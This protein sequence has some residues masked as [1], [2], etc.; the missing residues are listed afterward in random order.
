MEHENSLTRA[1]K[2][3]PFV[4]LG[5]LGIGGF[6]QTH[7]ARVMDKELVKEFGGQEVVA[8]K[9]PLPEKVRTLKRDLEMNTLLHLRLKELQAVNLVR[10]LGFDFFKGT[11]VLAFEY[12]EGGSLRDKI[13]LIG[14]QR[15][16]DPEEAVKIAEGVLQG[17]SVI[18]KEGIFHRDIKPENILIHGEIPKIADLGL[19]RILEPNGYASTSQ[20]TVQY[21][22]PDCLSTRGASF[23]SDIWSL[24]V[25]L[26]EMVTGRLPFGEP[27]TAIGNLVDLIRHDRHVPACEVCADVP[28][29]LSKIIDQALCKNPKDRFSGADEMLEALRSLSEG[30]N[31]PLEKEI[32]AIRELI[33]TFENP[34]LIESKLKEFVGQ[35][36]QNPSGYQYLGEFYNRCQRHD[37]ALSAF[38]KGLKIEPDSAM[39]RWNLA[40]TYQKMGKKNNAVQNL[41]KAISSGLDPGLQRHARILLKILR[42]RGK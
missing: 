33:T 7:K 23:T 29:A 12:I 27:D 6:A 5:L 26:Y 16:L 4:L 3:E 38:K 9:I 17:L 39:L 28:T 8:L 32:S 30:T 13:G 10:Y 19:S 42:G 14:A 20:G 40:L 1:D 36:N 31:D 37:E 41:K 22:S 34:R 24:G 2:K 15:R 25:T 21:M 18:H 35:Y 11:I